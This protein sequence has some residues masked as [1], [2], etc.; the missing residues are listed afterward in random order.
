MVVKRALDIIICSGTL[1]VI[2]PFLLII[3]SLVKLT[4]SGPVFFV[5]ERIGRGKR[6]FKMYKIR[7]M[8]VTHHASDVWTAADSFAVTPIGKFLRDYG[9]DELP[10]LFNILTGDMSIV[11]PRP[12]LATQIARYDERLSRTFDMRPGVL[13]LAAAKGRRSISAEERMELH[14]KYVED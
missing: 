10:Q 7:T 2:S 11:G 5:Q 4:S 9:L 8:R 3:S 6:V 12:P 1:I 14:L 13:S